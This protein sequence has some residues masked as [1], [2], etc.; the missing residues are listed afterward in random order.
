MAPT[1]QR[2]AINRESV[3]EPLDRMN[4][5]DCA[6]GVAAWSKCCCHVPPLA[7]TVSSQHVVSGLSSLSAMT[8][9]DSHQLQMRVGRGRE[10]WQVG[11]QPRVA[12]TVRCE[13]TAAMLSDL[14]RLQQQVLTDVYA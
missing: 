1:V 10:Q 14:A 4:V 3:A 9:N 6:Q 5:K 8:P 2:R 11:G 13:R 7:L 12:M